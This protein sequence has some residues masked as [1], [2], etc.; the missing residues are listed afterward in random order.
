MK[1]LLLNY[2]ACGD[3]G[4]GDLD[5]QQLPQGPGD[6]SD[7]P[8]LFPR[9]PRGWRLQPEEMAVLQQLT[10]LA[11]TKW[12]IRSCKGHVRKRWA[13]LADSGQAM[14]MYEFHARAVPVGA[15][16]AADDGSDARRHHLVLAD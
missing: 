12:G 14:R 9:L 5:G 1:R 16:R 2:V 13:T 8:I 11:Q 10:G 15:W 6:P 4:A 3:W 7:L